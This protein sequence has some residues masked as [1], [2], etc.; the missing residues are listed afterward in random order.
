MYI[1]K[2]NKEEIISLLFILCCLGL[3][4][5]FPVIGNFQ[6]ISIAIIFFVIIPILFDKI[7]LKRSNI[8][9]RLRIGNWKKG[10]NLGITGFL[11]GIFIFSIGI[12]FTDS[13]YKYIVP[14][15]IKNSFVS[16]FFYEVV[17]TLF[18]VAMYEFFFRGFIM[19]HFTNLFSKWAILIQA[20]IFILFISITGNLNWNFAPYI[21]FSPLAGFIAYKS[22]SLLYSLIFQWIFIISVD[23]IIASSFLK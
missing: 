11:I 17:L 10:L 13:T 15:F 3:Y 16:F 2:K 14:E 7:I 19:F 8:F 23:I 6:K 18:I 12:Y 4:I 21:I 20:I 9:Y 22:E 5:I 1:I